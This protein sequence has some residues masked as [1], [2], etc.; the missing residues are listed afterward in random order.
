MSILNFKLDKIGT[1][2][3]TEK[4]YIPQYQRGYSWESS[5][6]DD[7]WE[8]LQQLFNGS[9][10][11]EHFFGQIVVHN[12]KEENKRFIIDGQQRVS[13]SV[14]FLDVLRTK[15]D[16]LFNEDPNNEDARNDADDINSQY[17]G[18]ISE[19]RSDRKSVV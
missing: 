18:R 2:L 7:F 19:T 11:G 4:Y 16:E 1:F 5:Q 6:I 13:T 17:I 12:D 3:N 15:F 14:I 9:N 8:D 10:Q